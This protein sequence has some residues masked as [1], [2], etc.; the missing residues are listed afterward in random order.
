MNEHESILSPTS[1]APAKMAPPP[2]DL[3]HMFMDASF[4]EG[5]SGLGVVLLSADGTI[6]KRWAS[7]S[8]VLSALEAELLAVEFGLKHSQEISL[9]SFKVFSDS[10]TII[11]AV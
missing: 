1:L 7:T 9:K 3:P 8:K 2:S 5:K 11:Q 10:L 6:S 4:A